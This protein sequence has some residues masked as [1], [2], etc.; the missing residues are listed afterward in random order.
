MDIKEIEAGISKAIKESTGEVFSTM[1]M[2][3]VKSE[4][5]FVKAETNVST[6]LISSLHF[7][8]DRYM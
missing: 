1:L 7:F 6:D 8:G 5:S 4:D 3:D 2:M